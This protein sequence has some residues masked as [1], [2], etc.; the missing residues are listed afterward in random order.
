M[1]YIAIN[2]Y[3]KTIIAHQFNSFIIG[4]SAATCSNDRWF[5]VN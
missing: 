4:N 1:I 3:N 5:I 2:K